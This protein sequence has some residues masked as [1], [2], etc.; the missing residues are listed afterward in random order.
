[1]SRLHSDA[2]TCDQLKLVKHQRDRSHLTKNPSH[3]RENENYGSDL[4]DHT[5]GYLGEG[6]KPSLKDIRLATANITSHGSLT[7]LTLTE[8]DIWMIQ[9]HHLIKPDYV[10]QLRTKLLKQGWSSH[11]CQAIPKSTKGN[12]GGVGFVW[13]HYLD[14]CSEPKVVVPGRAAQMKFR[15]A[16]LG[17]LAVGCIYGYTGEKDSEQNVHLVKTALQALNYT[18]CNYI[19]G[20][21]FNCTPG[22]L[23]P[24]LAG[25]Q[26]NVRI[27]HSGQLTCYT[28]NG[29][30]ELDY[31]LTH[32]RLGRVTTQV[33]LQLQHS[34]A[35]HSPVRVTIKRAS[36]TNEVSVLKPQEKRDTRPIF[37]PMEDQT[38]KWKVWEATHKTALH[39]TRTAS[40]TRPTAEGTTDQE[41]ANL[42]EMVTDWIE[43]AMDE[44]DQKLGP[45]ARPPGR[46]EPSTDQ[47]HKLV[48]PT[49]TKETQAD[50][51]EWGH[52]RIQQLEATVTAGQNPS[53]VLN[54]MQ[55]KLNTETGPLAQCNQWIQQAAKHGLQNWEPELHEIAEDIAE[56]HRVL[57]KSEPTTKRKE[58]H[59]FLEQA[60]EGGASWAHRWTK[61]REELPTHTVTSTTGTTLT[62]QA[63]IQ[64][65][66]Q[67]WATYWGTKE[68]DSD[69]LVWPKAQMLPPLTTQEIWEAART[70]SGNTSAMDGMH[71]RT[72]AYISEEAAQA[73]ASI[74]QAVEFYGDF[75]PLLMQ[76]L[77]R[78]I[79]KP[80]TSDTRPIGLFRGIYRVWCKARTAIIKSLVGSRPQD[81]D[82]VNMM[83][84]RQTLDAVWRAQITAE[85]D[86]SQECHALAIL[87]DIAKCYENVQHANLQE[88]AI[89]QGYPL[90]TLRI[91]LA[92]YR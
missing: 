73:L 48:K 88:Q 81:S 65:Q 35:T 71:P 8:A 57:N 63:K 12:S 20:G 13:R 54:I 52:R 34:I 87:R 22:E 39:K 56:L 92:S 58:W 82:V 45:V 42:D 62:L 11:F 1:M 17:E 78:L 75:P 69:L 53:R 7:K 3:S 41:W 64:A 26:H 27:Q 4:F 37:G 10:K 85:G 90:Q 84:G 86:V 40:H 80:G 60:G 30:S 28:P 29:Q 74:L 47:V 70:F 59:N 46:Y 49:N 6:H 16:S 50:K 2:N 72:P 68:D 51:V 9:E 83:P 61:P 79:P 18:K 67:T 31:F 91:S 55:D 36:L 15:F 38:H 23:R 76:V 89:L 66:E 32:P 25:Q 44:L 43:Y 77:V 21:D 19:I 14:V 5:K 24:H 33:E